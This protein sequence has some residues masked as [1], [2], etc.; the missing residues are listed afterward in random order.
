MMSE[1]LIYPIVSLT[2]SNAYFSA[3]ENQVLKTF[4]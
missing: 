2:C 3:I 4:P 1:L